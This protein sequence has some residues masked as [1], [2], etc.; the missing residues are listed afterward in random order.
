[1]E[2][3]SG[4]YLPSHKVLVYSTQAAWITSRPKSNFTCLSVTLF[5]TGSHFYY[6]CY[7]YYCFIVIIIIINYYYY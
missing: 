4:G 3:N 2:V 5:E 6:Y 1:M 7:Y